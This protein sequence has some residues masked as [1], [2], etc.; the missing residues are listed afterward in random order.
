MTGAPILDVS[1]GPIQL[2]PSAGPPE[3]TRDGMISQA[4]RQLGAVGLFSLDPNAKLTRAGT[5]GF[6]TDKPAQPVLD[7]AANGVAQGFVEGANVDPV[8]EMTRLIT[9]TR[10][11]DGVTNGVTQTESSLT[12]AI[13][14]LGGAA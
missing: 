10:N 11:F 8:T 13:K 9:I 3:I 2:D 4:G 6:T 1:G 7:F 14:T 5:S 12:D